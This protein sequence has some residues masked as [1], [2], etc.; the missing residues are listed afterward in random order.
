MEGDLKKVCFRKKLELMWHAS[1]TL[2]SLLRS[3][4]IAVEKKFILLGTMLK[5]AGG[6]DHPVFSDYYAFLS[7]LDESTKDAEK[8]ER[9]H[10]LP[11][12]ILV[13]K[14]SNFVFNVSLSDLPNSDI[15]DTFLNPGFE[16][17]DDPETFVS[18]FFAVLKFFL[19]IEEG[20]DPRIDFAVMKALFHAGRIIERLEH[21]GK[22]RSDIPAKA[23]SSSWKK[24]VSKQEVIE[25]F[26]RV[27][28]TGKSKNAICEAVQ[29]A[30]VIQEGKRGGKKR[31]V[32][33]VKQIGRI[34]KEELKKIS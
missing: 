30:L 23:G 4:Q 17:S 25:M 26:Y 1:A 9:L 18:E 21:E 28:T 27:D 20:S 15:L 2:G 6:F 32:Y 14:A 11:L 12:G 33:S 34:L 7:N 8:I 13:E 31:D 16:F 19:V 24:K 29:E 3:Y 5:E 10:D 22:K